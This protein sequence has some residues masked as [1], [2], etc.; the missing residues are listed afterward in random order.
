MTNLP[1]NRPAEEDDEAR[2]VSPVTLCLSDKGIV[3]H[4][5]PGIAMGGPRAVRVVFC[6]YG[7]SV[8]GCE[9]GIATTRA[10]SLDVKGTPNTALLLNHL[11]MLE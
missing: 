6:S 10:L 8:G 7:F 5:H 11:H 3:A 1:A 4:F 9:K 2:T